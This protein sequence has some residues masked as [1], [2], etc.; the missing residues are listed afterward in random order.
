MNNTKFPD[1]LMKTAAGVIILK[2]TLITFLHK[3]PV[4]VP[5]NGH[6]STKEQQK[7]ISIKKEKSF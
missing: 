2:T 1:T 3:M 4:L 7:I 6:D 5:I